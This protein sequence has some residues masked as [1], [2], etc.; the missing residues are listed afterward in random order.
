LE[1]GDEL[2][3]RGDAI[4][5]PEERDVFNCVFGAKARKYLLFSG[6]SFLHDG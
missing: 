6:E 4:F 2:G 3:E 1:A 5:Q